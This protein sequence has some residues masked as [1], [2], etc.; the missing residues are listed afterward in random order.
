MKKLIFIAIIVLSAAQ[1]QGCAGDEDV[2]TAA[3]RSATERIYDEGVEGSFFEID[4]YGQEKISAVCVLS[5]YEDKVT[6]ASGVED[7]VNKYLRDIQHQPV[8]DR[9]ALVLI[10][11][12]NVVFIPFN[13]DD[14]PL[15]A[16]RPSVGGGSCSRSEK[17]ILY[18]AYN[19]TPGRGAEKL[20]ISLREKI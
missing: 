19:P 12:G 20:R 18:T 1:L 9:W 2:R 16:P 17:I 15:V 14:V 13:M 7:Q 4:R 5:A 11:S 8:E 3:I 10:V 6:G